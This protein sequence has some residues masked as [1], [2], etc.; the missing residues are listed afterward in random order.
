M[1]SHIPGDIKLEDIFNDQSISENEAVYEITLTPEQAT[2]GMEKELKRN[3]KKLKVKIP[4][5]IRNGSIVRLKNSLHLTDGRP[6]DIL[7]YIKVK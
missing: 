4:A 7:I 3:C 5:N 2:K 6:G 1:R